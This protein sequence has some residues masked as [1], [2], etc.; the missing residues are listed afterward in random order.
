MGST[1]EAVEKRQEEP[2]WE[3]RGI[4]FRSRC[5]KFEDNEEVIVLNPTS[6]TLVRVGCLGIEVRSSSLTR[7][8]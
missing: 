8:A 3:Q 4:D 6:L 1:V 5:Y 7:I 2:C